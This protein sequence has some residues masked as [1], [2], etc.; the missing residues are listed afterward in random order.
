MKII[1]K[2]NDITEAHLVAGMLNNHGIETYVGG[3]YL[4]G[5]MGRAQISD[6]ANVQV[7]EQDAEQAAHLIAE[8]EGDSKVKSPKYV[9][10]TSVKQL[11]RQQKKAKN[12]LITIAV[13]SVILLLAYFFK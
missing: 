13:S 6:F 5:A 11:T 3:H 12:A 8:Y 10:T 7:A 2:A 4:Q 1:Y 9:K